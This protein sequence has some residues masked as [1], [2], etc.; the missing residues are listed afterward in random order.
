MTTKQIGF[1]GIGN[2]GAPMAERLAAAGHALLLYDLSEHAVAP[3]LGDRV[4]SAGSVREVG[5]RA[6]IAF[7]SVPTPDIVLSICRGLAAGGR[8]R[9]VVDLSTTGPEMAATLAQEL[10]RSGVALV[11]CPVSGG[12][13][14]ARAGRLALMVGAS[15][16]DLA[17]VRPLLDC[18]GRVFHVGPHPGMGQMMKVINNLMSAAALAISSEGWP[19]RPSSASTLRRLLTS[20]TPAAAATARPWTSSR[21]RSSPG[22]S[23]QGSPSG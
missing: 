21:A 18:F 23:T 13:A 17:V 6:D 11:D 15:E 20:S 7:V 9:H 14:G 5:E 3:L 19:R 12:V 16:T 10:A 4:E 8:V 1:I 2:M 22:A